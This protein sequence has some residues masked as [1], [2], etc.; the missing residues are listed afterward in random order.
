MIIKLLILWPVASLALG[1]AVGPAMKE[2][3]R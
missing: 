2:A 3:T 1:L